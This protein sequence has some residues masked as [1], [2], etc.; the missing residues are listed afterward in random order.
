MTTQGQM[1]E[2]VSDFTFDDPDG[3]PPDHRV[4]ESLVSH[5]T[6]PKLVHENKSL[7]LRGLTLS[8]LVFVGVQVKD[9]L[10]DLFRLHGAIDYTPPP[11]LPV[12]NLLDFRKE[13]G[14]R[15]LNR[16]GQLV[17]MVRTTLS[18]L[19]YNLISLMH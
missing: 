18:T 11:L 15:F 2:A 10:V 14:A 4:Y 12:S 6:L 8:R 7:N 3:S 1:P 17:E 16:Q 9:R 19:C 5:T 13:P